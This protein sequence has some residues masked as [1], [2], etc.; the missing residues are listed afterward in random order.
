MKEN[1]EEEHEP[2][3]AVDG[4]NRRDE[5]RGYDLKSLNSNESS[6]SSDDTTI[7]I[8]ESSTNGFTPLKHI[9]IKSTFIK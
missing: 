2:I 5:A 1:L 4:S 9:K 7:V 6:K 3:L 8:D